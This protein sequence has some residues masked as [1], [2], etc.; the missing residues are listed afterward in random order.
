[1]KIEKHLLKSLLVMADIIEACDPYTGGHVWRVSQYA[2]LLATCLTSSA[3][4]MKASR[5]S[6]APIADL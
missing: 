2:K 3:T 1:M 4:A 5:L 6:P